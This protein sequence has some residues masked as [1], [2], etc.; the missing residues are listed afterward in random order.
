[1]IWILI[2]AL[3]Q[4]L[5]CTSG[6]F[7]YFPLWFL[8]AIDLRK[9]FKN[10][11]YVNIMRVFSSAPPPPLPPARVR[12][13]CTQLGS[14]CSSDLW[15]CTVADQIVSQLLFQKKI[16]PTEH[17]PFFICFVYLL[18]L[19]FGNLSPL[20][21]RHFLA[22]VTNRQIEHKGDHVSSEAV[23]GFRCVTLSNDGFGKAST[24]V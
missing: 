20:M 5:L 16:A 22:P 4:W 13:I 23:T 11:I 8:L 15:M 24:I 12:T 3:L 10:C 17:V 2:R 1:M 18:S 14:L 7:R 19:K 6:T 21:P 9:T